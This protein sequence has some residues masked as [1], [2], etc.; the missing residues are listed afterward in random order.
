MTAEHATGVII[1]T[2]GLFT[3]EAK[4]FAENKPL[5]LVEG[6]QLADLV[7]AAQGKPFPAAAEAETAR[8]TEMVCEE[9]G[10]KLVLR[11]AG[12]GKTAGSQF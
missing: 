4:S 1:M 8:A 3:Q 12:R 6:N 2:S 10:A 11:L 9:C 5:D 7:R